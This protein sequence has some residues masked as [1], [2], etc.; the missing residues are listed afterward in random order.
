LEIY[1]KRRSVDDFTISTDL[2]SS[3]NTP[4][5]PKFIKGET[6]GVSPMDTEKDEAKSG[7][8][9][10]ATQDKNGWQAPRKRRR[11]NRSPK[12]SKGN[13]SPP[14]GNSEHMEVQVSGEDSSEDLEL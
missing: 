2:Q 13:S 11:H 1:V 10:A 8:K 12:A 5:K 7:D 3:H 4:V 6:T 14:A 9:K